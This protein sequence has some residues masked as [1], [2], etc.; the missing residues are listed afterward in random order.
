LA[1]AVG[2]DPRA[3]RECDISVPVT[4]P[5]RPPR[6]IA[7]DLDGTLLRPDGSISERTRRALSGLADAGIELVFATARPPRWVDHLAEVVGAH[8]TVLCVN[9]A[10]VYDVPRRTV[11]EAHGMPPATVRAIAAD[12]RR[13]LPGVGFAAELPAGIRSEREYPA[14]HPEDAPPDDAYWPIEAIDQPA[15][16][17]LAR[18]RQVPDAEFLRRVADI[19]GGRALVTF[20]GDG[21]LAEI[22]PLGVTKGS[23]LVDWCTARGFSSGEVW[24]FG[25]M[26]NDLPMLA[27]AGVSFAVANAHPEVLAAASHVCPSNADDGVACVLE[28]LTD[29]LDPLA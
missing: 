10:F 13:A 23:T 12:L 9:G 1:P 14:L 22:G 4:I 3:Y 26:P 27:W 16:K 5:S 7:S 19:V 8:G 25:D 6:L 18:S 11:V 24:A 15:G 17:L 29:R 20:S 21:G 28:S 2:G